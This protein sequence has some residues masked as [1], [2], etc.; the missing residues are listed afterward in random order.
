[1]KTIHAA[2]HRRWLAVDRLL[3]EGHPAGDVCA[4]VAAALGVP[5]RSARQIVEPRVRRH[6]PTGQV[7]ALPLTPPLPRK[8][9]R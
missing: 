2:R 3:D 9:P 7:P 8:D 6:R 1:M 4:F 5:M